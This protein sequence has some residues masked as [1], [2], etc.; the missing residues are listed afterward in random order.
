MVA[1]MKTRILAHILAFAMVFLGLQ[2]F[3]YL[4]NNPPPKQTTLKPAPVAEAKPPRSIPVPQRLADDY[5]AMLDSERQA[6]EA[7]MQTV[8]YKDYQILQQQRLKQEAVIFGEC[9]CKPSA[10]RIPRD[11]Q[12]RI[13][14]DTNGRLE[15]I[16]CADAKE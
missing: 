4:Y 14:T 7:A 5:R 3:A 6:L 12:G 2:A 13:I 16:E 9:G 15:R 8:Q 10:A 11:Q 1:A